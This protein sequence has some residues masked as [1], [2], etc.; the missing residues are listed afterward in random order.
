MSAGYVLPDF[1]SHLERAAIQLRESGH[2]VAERQRDAVPL[3]V[4]LDE[5]GELPVERGQH[6]IEHLD[7]CH[8]EPGVD[9]VLRRLE[10][11][12]AAADHHR[13]PRRLH[14]LD[15]GVAG[16]PGQKRRAPFDPLADRPRV[17]HGPHLENPGRSMPGSGG[18]TD[19]APGDST[20]LS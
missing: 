7:E 1:V 11:D 14:E 17:R 2:P 13:T 18:R 3:H 20:S 10:T 15:T 6:L 4:L 9:Q 19:G 5:A 16:H 12:E 8:L